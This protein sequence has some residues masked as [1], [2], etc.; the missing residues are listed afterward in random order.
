MESKHAAVSAIDQQL[1]NLEERQNKAYELVETGVY[2]ADLFQQRQAA[3]SKERAALMTTK[4]ELISDIGN[5]ERIL[6]ERASIVPRIEH[7][8]D[9]Y[10]ALTDPL[11]KNTLLKSILESVTYHKTTNLRWSKENDLS[12]TIHPKYSNL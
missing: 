11:E 5:I 4:T 10:D 6:T 1:E 8:L 3:L 2:T 9:I 12:L 7:V